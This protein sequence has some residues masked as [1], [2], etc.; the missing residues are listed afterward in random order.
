MDLSQIQMIIQMI[1][2]FPEK[3]CSICNYYF[4]VRNVEAEIYKRL[5][6]FGIFPEDVQ[7]SFGRATGPGGQ[8]VN[9]T[10]TA[11]SLNCR[12]ANIRLTAQDSRS[13]WENRRNAW[14][15][16]I[17]MLEEKRRK[18]HMERHQAIEKQKRAT[19]KRPRGLKEKILAHKK[20]RSEIKRLRGKV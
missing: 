16:L 15:R 19:R 20:H 8:H 2:A 1:S 11:V 13:Q 12:K 9:K 5:E 17:D 6:R 4:S 7:E 3:I 14:Q 10:S 18:L